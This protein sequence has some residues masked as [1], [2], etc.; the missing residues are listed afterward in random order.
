MGRYSYCGSQC[1]ILNTAIGAFT[2]I[3][4]SVMIGGVKH[5]FNLVGTSKIFQR[6]RNPFGVTMGNFPAHPM[7]ETTIGHDVFVGKSAFIS[8]GVNVGTGAIVGAGAIVTKDVPPYA[9]VAGVPAR[10]LGYRFPEDIRERLLSSH[11]WELPKEK[12]SDLSD[13]FADPQEFLR[14]ME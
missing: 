2:S 8:A 13:Y 6:G 14:R 10:V 7:G 9:I 12:L 5:N 3:A 1:T 4:D 11:W